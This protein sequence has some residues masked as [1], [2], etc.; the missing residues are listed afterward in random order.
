MLHHKGLSIFLGWC[1][2]QKISRLRRARASTFANRFFIICVRVVLFVLGNLQLR[3]SDIRACANALMFFVLY[4][5][6]LEMTQLNIQWSTSV[7]IIALHFTHF[8][9]SIRF[10]NFQKYVAQHRFQ[11]LTTISYGILHK[12]EV[13]TPFGHFSI[14]FLM[15][16]NDRLLCVVAYGRQLHCAI[17]IITCRIL[18]ELLKRTKRWNIFRSLV[19]RSLNIIFFQ[20]ADCNVITHFHALNLQQSQFYVV[21]CLSALGYAMICC[22]AV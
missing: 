3:P 21:G 20:T 4:A 10:V 15:P 5:S 14:L 16:L 1:F 2:P 9:F 11:K 12:S 18:C 22:I 19:Q 13:V 8:S 7:A 6:L 17:H